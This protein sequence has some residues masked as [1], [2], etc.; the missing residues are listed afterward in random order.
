MMRTV[1]EQV[2]GVIASAFDVDGGVVQVRDDMR[3]ADDL[4]ADELDRVELYIDLEEA[5]GVEVLDAHAESLVT[6][7]DVIALVERLRAAT[8]QPRKN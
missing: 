1:A 8:T 6:V 7:G 4:N 3:L 2:R 5:F